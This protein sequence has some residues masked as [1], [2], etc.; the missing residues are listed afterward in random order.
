MLYN[1]TEYY[2]DNGVIQ[3]HDVIPDVNVVSSL[4]SSTLGSAYSQFSDIIA[5]GNK[6]MDNDDVSSSIDEYFDKIADTPDFYDGNF[7]ESQCS[8]SQ[9]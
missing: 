4:G 5:L 6:N 8:F 3:T 1:D 2:I 7:G 9:L